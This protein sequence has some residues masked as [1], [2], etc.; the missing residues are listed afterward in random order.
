VILACLRGALQGNSC[1]RYPCPM[2][3]SDHIDRDMVFILRG[4]RGKRAFLAVLIN[5]L[6]SPALARLLLQGART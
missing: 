2:R 4:V 3:L 5:E 1:C 6:A